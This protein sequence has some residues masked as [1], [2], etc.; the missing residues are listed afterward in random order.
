MVALSPVLGLPLPAGAGGGQIFTVNSTLDSDDGCAAE[1]SLRDA[2]NAANASQGADEI[3]FNI[4]AGGPA[5]IQ[6]ASSLPTITD[7]VT[8]D[9]Y[10]QGGAQP[11]TLPLPT[12]GTNA[13]L[14]IVLDGTA[15]IDVGLKFRPG[16]DG[17]LVKG[18][19]I[20]RFEF[21]GLQLDDVDDIAI[22]GNFV[23]T[24]AAGTVAQGNEFQGINLRQTIGP[25]DGVTIG[26]VRPEQRNLVSGN[27]AQ[28]IQLVGAT[29]VVIQGNL[30]GTAK[31]G[32][33]N[34]GN[35]T[36]VLVDDGAKNA[37]IGG[38][39]AEAANVIAFNDAEGVGVDADAARAT[40]SCATRSSPMANSAST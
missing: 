24:N 40:A 3:R 4:G 22:E 14:N 26:G 38:T 27:N 21:E 10:S 34:L 39:T 20:H 18:L 30:I 36:G 12:Q 37:T 32:T 2:I 15:T 29:N 23:G 17:S 11:N 1:C 31:N 19:V 13:V 7:R 9:G 35:Q 16:S 28:G 8:I 5:A 6:P 33:A 25:C